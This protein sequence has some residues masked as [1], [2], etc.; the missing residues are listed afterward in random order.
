MGKLTDFMTAIPQTGLLGSALNLISQGRQNQWQANQASLQNQKNAE[1]MKYQ[2]D[3]NKKMFDQANLYNSP[4]QQMERYKQAGLN[5]NLI[6]GQ[7]T[8]GNSPNVLP[9]YRAPDY[10]A[11]I[12]RPL[13]I[14]ETLG[15]GINTL[16]DLTRLKNEQKQG[17]IL[18]SEATIKSNQAV[19][20]DQAEYWKKEALMASG[21]RAY[22][23]LGLNYGIW[24]GDREYQDRVKSGL[25]FQ[26]FQRDTSK[27]FSDITKIKA[28]TARINAQSLLID[29]QKRL[30]EKNIE[31]RSKEIAGYM[32]PLGKSLWNAGTTIGSGLVR[33]GFGLVTKIA[34]LNKLKGLSGFAKKF[35]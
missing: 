15:A 21:T 5:P 8:P 25:K 34:G 31:M 7:G 2:F 6:Y 29:A 9:Q 35:Q 14:S 1:L 24:A 11:N 26:T 23:D 17:Q 27:I 3:M 22:A 30:A 10:E 16:L 4:L 32:T 13:N 12:R 28:D 20:S 33:G 19:Y 18:D